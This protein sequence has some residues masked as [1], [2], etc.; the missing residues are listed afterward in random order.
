[1]YDTSLDALT[2]NFRRMSL[3]KYAQCPSPSIKLCIELEFICH[4]L[5]LLKVVIIFLS[6]FFL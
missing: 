2:N 5:Q 6:E 1:M 4:R 3:R